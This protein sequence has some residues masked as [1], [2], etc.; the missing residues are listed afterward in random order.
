MRCVMC[1][2]PLKPREIIWYP[3]EKRHEEYCGRCR[4]VIT[5]DMIQAG[6]D[7]E[8]VSVE[9]LTTDDILIEGVDEDVEES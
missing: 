2:A 3:E 5:I 8:F 9:R 1:D 6:D 4:D 7:P